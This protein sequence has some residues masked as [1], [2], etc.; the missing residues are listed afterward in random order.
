MK[1]PT[2]YFY[3]LLYET[4]LHPSVPRCDF[5]VLFGESL[6]LFC[7]EEGAICLRTVLD[8]ALAFD[9]SGILHS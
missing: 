5:F 7:S 6:E 1:K 4:S 3:D 9:R 2:C 8:E